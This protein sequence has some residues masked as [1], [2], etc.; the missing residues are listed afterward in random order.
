MMS[1][2]LIFIDMQLALSDRH[3][4]NTK[5]LYFAKQNF[6]KTKLKQVGVHL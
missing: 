5:K 1:C 3:K 2:K 4:N 6:A